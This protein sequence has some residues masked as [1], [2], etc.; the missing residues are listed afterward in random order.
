MI[1]EKSKVKFVVGPDLSEEPKVKDCNGLNVENWRW[2]QQ[3][4]LEHPYEFN[5]DNWAWVLDQE[6]GVE[7]VEET[8]TYE[9][10]AGS[11]RTV[12]CCAGT[13]AFK[14]LREGRAELGEN[15]EEV[16]LREL[17]LK[18]ELGP[19]AFRSRLFYVDNWPEPFREMFKSSKDPRRKA[20]IF[21]DLID[22]VIENC[23]EWGRGYGEEVE[24]EE[25]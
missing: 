17:G 21:S 10:K 3:W 7:E 19:Y 23:E 13:I 18:D 9:M 20:L 12:G 4:V 24:S 25:A 11:C 5:M 16:G 2:L 15:I 22:Y 8:L 1:K 6:G 14:A